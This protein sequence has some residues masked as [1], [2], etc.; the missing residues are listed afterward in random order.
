MDKRFI[1]G[2]VSAMCF[3]GSM[4]FA[5]DKAADKKTASGGGAAGAKAPPVADKKEEPAKPEMKMETPKPS[6]ETLD[7]AKAM[8]G[9]WACSVTIHMNGQDMKSTG[10]ITWKSDLDNFWL[11]GTFAGKKAKDN[12]TPYNFVEHRMYDANQKKWV[13]AMFDNSGSMGQMTGTA[14]DKKID[15]EGK[16]MEGTMTMYSKSTEEMVSAKE[17]K[18]T[19]QMSMDGK[20]FNPAYE[21]DCKK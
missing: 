16:S 20:T 15:W 12:P 14:G 3:A 18:I 19:G 11:T 17:V 21:V 8:K 10:T 5:A 9:T 2:V 4:A 6:Q 7:A 13:S 1:A